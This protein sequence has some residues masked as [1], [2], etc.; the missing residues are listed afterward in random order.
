MLFSVVAECL[1]HSVSVGEVKFEYFIFSHDYIL[2]YIIFP[3]LDSLFYLTKYVTLVLALA[4]R[5]LF[6]SSCWF[7]FNAWFLPISDTFLT[8]CA[9][10]S[11]FFTP[12]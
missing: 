3:Y 1:Y 8:T 12:T 4:K 2:N 9:W 7:S 6:F 5:N 10:L 11:N